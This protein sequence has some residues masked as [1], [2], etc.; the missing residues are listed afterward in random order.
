MKIWGEPVPRLSTP[1]PFS[2]RIQYA[3]FDMGRDVLRSTACCRC[4]ALAKGAWQG[5]GRS[6]KKGWFINKID[7]LAC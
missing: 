4:C 3:A 5:G 7:L 1:L 6:G 2:E